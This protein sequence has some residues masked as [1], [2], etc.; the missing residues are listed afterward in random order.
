[1][2]RNLPSKAEADLKTAIDLAPQSS[3]PYLYLGKLRFQQ[4]RLSEG[5]DLMEQA[6]QNDPNDVDALRLLTNDDLSRN[7]PRRALARVKAQIEKSPANGRL[8]DLLA[9]LQLKSRSL[10]QAAAAS[11]RPFR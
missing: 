7:Q 4:K 5:V 11:R 10:D 9:K 3:L 2:D 6:L 1:M 8:Y